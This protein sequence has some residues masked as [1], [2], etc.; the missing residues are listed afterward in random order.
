MKV[1]IELNLNSR[2]LSALRNG[3]NIQIGGENM[4]G[5]ML[6][7]IDIHAL[8]RINKAVK[9]VKEQ[10]YQQ[11]IYIWFLEMVL[12]LKRC[13]KLFQNQSKIN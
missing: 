6:F 8:N 9:K 7:E 4:G 12:I 11:M 13:L 1:K 5:D 3:K 2:Q 10:E